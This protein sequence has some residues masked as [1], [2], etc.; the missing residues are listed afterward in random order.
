MSVHAVLLPHPA[1]IL[2]G[3][4]VLRGE[5]GAMASRNA[6]SARVLLESRRTSQHH[7][8][9]KVTKYSSLN[10]PGDLVTTLRQRSG[11]PSPHRSQYLLASRSFC[12]GLRK[13]CCTLWQRILSALVSSAWPPQLRSVVS[14][15]FQTL[16][17]WLTCCRGQTFVPP[18]ITAGISDKSIWTS[19][20]T[21]ETRLW[22]QGS[23]RSP[24]ARLSSLLT[25]SWPLCSEHRFPLMKGKP[26]D[27]IN[28]SNNNMLLVLFRGF[29]GLRHLLCLHGAHAHSRCGELHVW[30][31]FNMLMLMWFHTPGW[32]F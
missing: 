21:S 14:L 6:S 17:R 18:N 28:S 9:G 3:H 32:Q 23:S 24:G 13:V 12:R 1:Q 19:P 8:S 26:S 22:R 25:P 7:H 15:P 5:G 20:P 27:S 11:T 16:R 30:A 4:F 31:S 10:Y 29:D 2:M